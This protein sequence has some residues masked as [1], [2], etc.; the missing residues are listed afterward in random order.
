MKI[1][2]NWGKTLEAEVFLTPG[3]R[4]VDQDKFLHVFRIGLELDLEAFLHTRDG[5]TSFTSPG[6]RTE[7]D[8]CID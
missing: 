3:R 6:R 7:E 5:V 2:Q 4:H 8:G 1:N